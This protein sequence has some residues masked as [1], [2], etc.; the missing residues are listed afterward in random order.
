MLQS[1]GRR[2]VELVTWVI[3][4]E[5]FFLGFEGG[6]IRIRVLRCGGGGG[7]FFGCEGDFGDGK[8]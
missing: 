5:D 1:A 7:G 4:F 6:G 3:L 8:G 2:A